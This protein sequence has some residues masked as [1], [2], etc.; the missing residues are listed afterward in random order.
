[1][2]RLRLEGH[3]NVSLCEFVK[4]VRLAR[5]RDGFHGNLPV[6]TITVAR[7]ILLRLRLL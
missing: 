6:Y 2:M 3:T 7:H 5:P 1:M 4:F